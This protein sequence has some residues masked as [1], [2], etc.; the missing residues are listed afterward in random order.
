M[1]HY[2]GSQG[3][4]PG[5]HVD[6]SNPSFETKKL[7][8]PHSMDSNTSKTVGA[9]GDLRGGDKRTVKQTPWNHHN[10]HSGKGCD[11]Q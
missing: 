9:N 1:K 2:S 8:I 11:N 10:H 5:N 3:L 6:P 7:S 4:N